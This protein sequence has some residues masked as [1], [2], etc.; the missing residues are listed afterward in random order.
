MGLS[1]EGTFRF[2]V[3]L[4]RRVMQSRITVRDAEALFRGQLGATTRQP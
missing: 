3:K 4:G 1:E 2:S